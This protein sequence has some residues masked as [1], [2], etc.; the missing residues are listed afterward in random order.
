MAKKSLMS[1]VNVYVSDD[2]DNDELDQLLQK[3][4]LEEPDLED[5]SNSNN[6][7]NGMIPSHVP[8]FAAVRSPTD[9]PLNEMSLTLVNEG[10]NG[11]WHPEGGPCQ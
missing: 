2:S 9:Q 1:E 7:E 5:G 4:Q 8:L 10:S 3:V 11:V 6:N